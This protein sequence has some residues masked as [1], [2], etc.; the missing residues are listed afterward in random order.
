MTDSSPVESDE[1]W[2]GRNY[3]SASRLNLQH[4]MWKDAQ[5]FLLHPVIQ[6][7]LRHESKS[8]QADDKQPLHVA[9]VATGTGIWLFDLLKSQETHDVAIQYHGFDISQVLFPHKAWLP[10]NVVLSTSNLLQEP[11]QSLHGQFDVV[12]I[13]LVLSLVG[14]DSPRPIIQHVKKLLKPGGYLQWDEFDPPNQH[15]VVF[16]GPET[17]ASKLVAVFKLMKE[18]VDPSWVQILPQTLEEE[19]F[20]TAAQSLYE[21]R[22][23]MFKAWTYMD[24]CVMEELSRNRFRRED[25]AASAAL[26]RLIQEA[27]AEADGTGA[28][29]RFR[30][31][32]TIARK[33]L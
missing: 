25:E 21:P 4:F 22:T 24:L 14:K 20:E 23:E 17:P 30:P 26:R 8:R 7:H 18:L 3:A 11:P 19:G 2:L 5:D 28:V 12:H 16:P 32:I 6:A 31:A 27:H 9:D 33:P 15:K 29:V 10:K 13:R 1:Y